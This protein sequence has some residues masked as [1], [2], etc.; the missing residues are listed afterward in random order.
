[1]TKNCNELNEL[2]FDLDLDESTPVA[3]APVA[4]A[5]ALRRYQCA[6]FFPIA[7]A[8]SATAAAAAN[9]TRP[10]VNTAASTA[11][12]TAFYQVR[13]LTITVGPASKNTIIGFDA[14]RSNTSSPALSTSSTPSTSRASPMSPH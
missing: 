6:T 14:P 1:M 11:V 5:P 8:R 3:S 4:S 10:L 13:P 9:E 2:Q 12:S 7:S